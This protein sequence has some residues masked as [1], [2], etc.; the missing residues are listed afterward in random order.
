M[1][2]A[3]FAAFASSCHKAPAPRAELHCFQTDGQG[4]NPLMGTFVDCFDDAAACEVRAKAESTECRATLPRWHCFS[5]PSFE[6]ANDPLDGIT[7]CYPSLALCN[8]VRTPR[9][10]LGDDQ[11]PRSPCTPAEAVY[12]EASEPLLCAGSE[13][14]CNRAADMAADVLFGG[15]PHG[16][17][18]ARHSVR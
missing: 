4:L 14:L 2:A 15:Q 5:V 8:A 10:A 6:P 18:V 7:F 13:A 12:C 16:R 1:L 17:C 11:P 3:C 9:S